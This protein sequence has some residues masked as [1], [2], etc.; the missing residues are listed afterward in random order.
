M[1][2]VGP[3]IPVQKTDQ[4]RIDAVLNHPLFMDEFDPDFKMPDESFNEALKSLVFNGT[5]LEIAEDSKQKGNACFAAGKTRFQDSITFYTQGI[6]ANCENSEL[7]S[8]LHSNRAAVHLEL[9]NYRSCLYDCSRAIKFNPKNIKAYYRSVKALLA[10]DKVEE[11]I[12]CCEKGSALDP[13]LFLGDLA[14]L[15]KRKLELE[16]LHRLEMEKEAAK[17]AKID[18][19]EQMKL[20]RGYNI[21]KLDDDIHTMQHP[22]APPNRITIQDGELTFPVLFL[23]PEFNQSD[24]ISQ[25]YESDTFYVHFENM[26]SQPSE[27]DPNHIYHPQNLDIYY[28]THPDPNK[29]EPKLVS[30][31][32]TVHAS[33]SPSQNPAHRYVYTTLQDCLKMKDYSVVNN[34]ASFIILCRDSPFG[35][36]YRKQFNR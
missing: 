19:L 20:S 25:F 14:K 10:L 29:E 13:K 5:P 32:K 1:T 34:V 21:I 26:F 31:L 18:E 30:V 3:E 6:Q 27:W 2:L 16:E 28:T 11:G 8:I 17:K 15:Q 22:D 4:E 9:L 35:Q 33:K 24:L 12:D 23:Y 7:N 36:E